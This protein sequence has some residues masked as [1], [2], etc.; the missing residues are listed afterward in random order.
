MPSRDPEVYRAAAEAAARRAAS[1][2]RRFETLARAGAVDAGDV[3]TAADALAEAM[4]RAKRARASMLAARARHEAL[5]EVT[6]LRARAPF[7]PGAG[8]DDPDVQ[9]WLRERGVALDELFTTYL[10]V[11]G[12]CSKLEIDAFVHGAL[13]IPASEQ[14]ALRHA[15]WEMDSF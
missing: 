13:S 5:A 6:R 15:M 9:R 4:R 3:A 8:D 7:E 11:G 1:C 14:T 2:R 10:V 12:T